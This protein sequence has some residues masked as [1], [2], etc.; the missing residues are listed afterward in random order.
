[1][2]WM[3]TIPIVLV[4]ALCLSAALL[5]REIRKS[6]WRFVEHMGWRERSSFRASRYS[7]HLYEIIDLAARDADITLTWGAR[8]ML[9]IP[10]IETLE[11]RAEVNWEENEASIRDIVRAMAEDGP[12][13]GLFG[14]NRNSVSTI[15]AFWRRYCNIPPFC[16]R[17]EEKR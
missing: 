12:I 4:A 14:R 11:T 13:V 15:R 8:E 6:P 16:S 7:H 9:A 5:M 2:T 3:Q 1:M 17:T 10:I